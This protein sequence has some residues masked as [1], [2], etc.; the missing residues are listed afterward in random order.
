MADKGQLFVSKKT[1]KKK[2][3]PKVDGKKSSLVDTGTPTSGSFVK[4]EKAAVKQDSKKGVFTSFCEIKSNSKDV[5]NYTSSLDVKVEKQAKSKEESERKEKDTLQLQVDNNIGNKTEVTQ[6][7]EHKTEVTQNYVRDDEQYKPTV[8]R[9]GC[10]CPVGHLQDRDADK[11]QPQLT[12]SEKN[13]NEPQGR[14]LSSSILALARKDKKGIATEVNGD[15]NTSRPHLCPVNCNETVFRPHSRSFTISDLPSNRTPII[16]EEDAPVIVRRRG[17]TLRVRITPPN[18]ANCLDT[19]SDYGPR[20]PSPSNSPRKPLDDLSAS[21]IPRRL[22]QR[23]LSEDVRQ[24][25]RGSMPLS[26]TVRHLGLSSSQLSQSSCLPGLGLSHSAERETSNLLRMRQ[27]TLGH[28]APNLSSSGPVTT[29]GNMKELSLSKTSL[30]RRGSRSQSRKSIIANTSPTL[31]LR[32]HSPQNVGSPLDSPRTMSP[33]QHGHFPFGPGKS[34]EG[35]RRWSFASLPSSGYGTNTPGSSNVSSQC[36]S[37]EKLHQLPYQPTDRELQM[38][39]KHFDSSENIAEAED[40]GRLSPVIRPRSRSL[41]SPA[42]SPGMESDIMM[43]NTVYKDRFPNA[44]IEMEERLDRFIEDNKVLACSEES[45]GTARF[46]HHQILELARDCLEKSQEQVI[47]VNYFIELSEN[48]QTLLNDSRERSPHAAEHADPMVNRLLIIISRPARLL[49]CLEFDPEEFYHLL[50]AAEG[51]ARQVI[52][53]DIPQYIVNKLGLNRDPLADMNDIELSA[54]EFTAEDKDDESEREGKDEE[55]TGDDDQD[56]SEEY[57]E[58]TEPKEAKPPCEDDFETIKLISN[59]AYG[60]VFLVRHRETRQ[61]FA[62]K[63]VLKHNLVLRNQVEQAFA[64]RDILTFTD[65]PFV[66]SLYCTFETKKYL[67]MVLEYVEG[68]DCATLLKNMGPLP[69][70]MARLY[71]AETVLA[72]EYLHSYGIVHRDLKPDNLLIT[73]TGHIK[74]TDFGLSKI[75]LMNLTTNMYE[76]SI[77][78][79]SKQFKDKQVFGTPEYIAPEVI[80]RKGYGKPVD[81]WSMGVI[82]YEFLVGCVPFFGDTTEELF[83]QVINVDIEWPEEEEYSVDEDSKNLIISLLQQNPIDR[84]GTGGAHEVREHVFFLGLD[85]DG[86]LRQKAEFIPQLD[87]EEDTSY[88]DT[89]VDRY[90]HDLEDTE[91]DADDIMFHSFSSMSPRYSKVYGKFAQMRE[92]KRQEEKARSNSM[93]AVPDN[94]DK[95]VLGRKNS[96]I[97]ECSTSSVETPSN[98][99]RNSI[100]DLEKEV[101]TLALSIKV[102]EEVF[103]SPEVTPRS[104]ASNSTPESSQC[105]SDTLSPIMSRKKSTPKAVKTDPIP[106]FSISAEEEEEEHGKIHDTGDEPKKEGKKPIHIK[107]KRPEVKKKEELVSQPISSPGSSSSRDASPSRDMLPVIGP[108]RPA[109]IIRRSPRGYGFTPKAIRVYH[110]DTDIYTLHHLVVHV[111]DNGPA[112][113]AGLR[114]GNLITHVNTECVVGML[115]V[116]VIKLILKD[117]SRVSLRVTPL[118]NTTIKT[119]GRYRAPHEGKMTRRSYKKKHQR[120]RS[121]DSHHRKRGRTSLFRRLSTKRAQE[122]NINSPIT[123]S[124][125]FGC[126]LNRSLS[127]GDSMPNS[128]TRSKSPRSPPIGRVY[129]GAGGDSVGNTSQSSSS[130]SSVPNSPASSSQ[131]NRPSSLHGLKHKL[132]AAKSPHRRKSVHNIPLSPLARTPSPSPMALSPTRSPSPLTVVHGHHQA[133]SSNTTQTYPTYLNSSPIATCS[134]SKKTLTRPKSTEPGQGSPALPRRGAS[135]DR[136]H[137]SAAKQTKE[138]QSLNRKSSW[139]EK[140][141]YFESL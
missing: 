127:S 77:D 26:P 78:K 57:V 101:P 124:K 22:L 92:R 31:P 126:T 27:S 140:R 141:E 93:S 107:P 58:E 36:S 54:K 129:V 99:Q 72:L 73:S 108:L 75:G 41:S 86:L 68:G 89:R 87:S 48:L 134:L 32:C 39:T 1:M 4:D 14:L 29:V 62:L 120:E 113:E 12:A 11:G 52:Q 7:K 117:P 8:G 138:K 95:D 28:S 21:I 115:H 18:S 114:P 104:I 90:N 44:K 59:G 38:L 74:L 20:S 69:T 19:K 135:P 137:P 37:Q 111:D 5:K 84:L 139:H 132:A 16:Y 70:D 123:P 45:D 17:T 119:G 94:T 130:G 34:R 9:R 60:A 128:P 133:G 88:F 118:D 65:N 82:L 49:E 25:R 67:C 80:L 110:G 46:V 10:D 105:E 121:G 30:C 24:K 79:E 96:N 85:W 55:R 71:F 6:D 106:L 102:D 47:S 103:S 109:F 15:G 66:V 97:S 51:Q 56:G 35:G 40:D 64:E 13:Q 112:Y 136:L 33:S 83:S 91:D 23:T 125:T 116:Q 53:T 43:M 63:K 76:G 100:S 131:F 2:G 3:T 42:K 61:R 98:S 122:Q 81:W 50:E